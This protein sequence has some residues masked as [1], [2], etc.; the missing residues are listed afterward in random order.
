MSAITSMIGTPARSEMTRRL[1]KQFEVLNREFIARCIVRWPVFN[2]GCIWSC[3]VSGETS[4]V[5]SAFQKLDEV[6]LVKPRAEVARYGKKFSRDL[7]L[8][9]CVLIHSRVMMKLNAINTPS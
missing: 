9:G 1:L 4:H 2:T 3:N 7:A 6:A 8:I 5:V